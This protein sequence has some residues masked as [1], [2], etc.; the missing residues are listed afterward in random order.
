MATYLF[1][2]RDDSL[3][4]AAPSCVCA[5]VLDKLTRLSKVVNAK[6]H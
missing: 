4:S 3:P 2:I 5:A 1:H 6:L